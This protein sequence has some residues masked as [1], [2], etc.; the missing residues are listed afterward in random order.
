MKKNI[1]KMSDIDLKDKYVMIREDLNVPLRKNKITDKTR[2]LKALPTIK[3]ALSQG[4]RV[5][6]LSHLGSPVEGKYDPNF[7][8]SQITVL[9]SNLLNRNVYLINRYTKNIDLRPGEIAVLENIRFNSGEKKNSP[10]LSQKLAN[11]CDVFVMD[12]FA[13]AHREHASTLGVSKYAKIACVGPLLASEVINLSNQIRNIES[14]SVAIIGGL[15]VST[16][17]KMLE[18]LVNMVDFLLVGGGIANTFLKASGYE[19]GES[20]YEDNLIDSARRILNK[21]KKNNVLII[22]PVDVRVRDK[23]SF[24]DST[25]KERDS[26]TVSKNETILDIGTKTEKI[27][28]NIIESAKTVIWNGPIGAFETPG[29]SSGTRSVGEAI[30]LSKARSIAGGGDTISAINTFDLH[31]KITYISTGGGAFMHFLEQGS[32]PTVSF[33]EEISSSLKEKL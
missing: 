32:L 20:F 25:P 8:L 4:A 17:L 3:N 10:V 9:I 15:K 24:F 30:A 23:N 2:I 19:I 13:T 5:I 11:L 16:K 22:L 1:L 26:E 33:L 18:K 6:I 21:A 31:D 12:A 14:P 27:Y 7:S 29:F 28:K